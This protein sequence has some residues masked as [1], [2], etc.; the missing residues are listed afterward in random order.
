MHTYKNLGIFSTSRQEFTELQLSSPT[1]SIYHFPPDEH[2]SY[3]CLTYDRRPKPH[4]CLVSY[5]L[6]QQAGSLS[7][8]TTDGTCLGVPA[9]KP[10][11]PQHEI[12]HYLRSCQE[13]A[14]R[15]VI[16]SHSMGQRWK[17]TYDRGPS[18]LGNLPATM[19]LEEAVYHCN[20]VAPFYILRNEDHAAPG[21]VE[22]LLNDL[23]Y[24]LFGK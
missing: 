10:P 17:H 7:A 12:L 3:F 2:Q 6:I 1:S 21:Y 13:V 19:S 11:L 5:Q 16:W 9:Q 14:Y 15:D 24:Y 4:P 8:M 22:L 20:R 23:L 18:P